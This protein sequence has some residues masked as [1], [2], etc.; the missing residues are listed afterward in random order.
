M[1]HL[2]D[3]QQAEKEYRARKDRLWGKP[4]NILPFP[5]P[6]ITTV[7]KAEP[8]V[9]TVV[10]E[11]PMVVP[12]E[13]DRLKILLTLKNDLGALSN[14]INAVLVEYGKPSDERYYPVATIIRAV[15][16]YYKISVRDM[17]SARRTR[18]VVRPRQVAM[19]LAKQLTLRS[20]PDI[21]RRFGGRD[22]TTVLHAVRKIESLRAINPE[23]DRQLKELTAILAEQPANAS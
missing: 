2:E 7:V 9:L 6:T 21:G 17:L 5:V 23:L 1:S 8:P 20:L 15:A 4:K 10:P 18:S 13:N 11:V 14:R 12:T 19:Y 16:G 22:H 3:R